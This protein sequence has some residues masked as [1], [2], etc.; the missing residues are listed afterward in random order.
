MSRIETPIGSAPL[1]MPTRLCYELKLKKIRLSGKH[2]R[3]A[4]FPVAI[5]ALPDDD[6]IW[7]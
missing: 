5:S 2:Q 6:V 3:S 1:Q 4:T 7:K